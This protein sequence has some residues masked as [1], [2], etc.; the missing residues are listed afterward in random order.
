MSLF[1]L[2][3]GLALWFCGFCSMTRPIP[4]PL[5]LLG[6]VSFVLNTFLCFFLLI[7]Y[8][9]RLYNLFDHLIKVLWLKKGW[10]YFKR[11]SKLPQKWHLIGYFSK[12]IAN[13]MSSSFNPN[14]PIITTHPC[15][16]SIAMWNLRSCFLW[17]VRFFLRNLLAW[18]TSFASNGLYSNGNILNVHQTNVTNTNTM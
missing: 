8:Y 18:I 17:L 4:F 11:C 13:F 6:F 12:S 16:E 5:L 9:C 14:K 7:L 2:T 10:W 3:N 15:T 1:T